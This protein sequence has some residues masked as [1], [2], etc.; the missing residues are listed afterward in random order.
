[1]KRDKCKYTVVHENIQA[2][3]TESSYEHTFYATSCNLKLIR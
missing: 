3:T 1:M 2:L